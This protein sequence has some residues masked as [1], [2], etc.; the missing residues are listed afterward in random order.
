MRFLSLLLLLPLIHACQQDQKS[1]PVEAHL[2]SLPTVQPNLVL[3]APAAARIVY[4][5]VDGQNWQ[6]ASAGLPERINAMSIHADGKEILL[7][8][9]SGL[10]HSNAGGAPS[11]EAA[12]FTPEKII[13]I[14]PGRSGLYAINENGIFQ[15]SPGM[16][17][18]TPEYPALKNQWVRD[19]IETPDGVLFAACSE[20]VFTS[21]DGGN[22][23]KKVFA[24]DLVTGLVAVDGA[25][26]GS[27]NNG[28][29]RSTDGGVHWDRVF[30]GP[31]V[32][33]MEL[34]GKM[35]VA[36]T[37]KE[38]TRKTPPADGLANHL[39]SSADGGKTWQR[40]D[41]SLAALRNVYAADERAPAFWSIFD[42]EQVGNSL[43]CSLEPGIFR[44]SDG[45]NSWEL[46]LPSSGKE[47]LFDMTVSGGVLY[48][49]EV[50]VM[51]C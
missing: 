1:L 11:W 41:K 16:N 27:S 30:A 25:L 6:D 49:V 36:T 4:Q 21:T 31:G 13:E 45:G 3:A 50:E 46:V 8:T 37:F 15:K 24:G 43:Y 9:G 20:G 26:I 19:L 40:L 18:W 23:W 17:V 34:L 38:D 22:N 7:S 44:S 35:L 29:L 28:I 42:F 39:L 14:F 32:R 48:A 47:M 12:M 33:K 51:D 10:F 5:S 2:V